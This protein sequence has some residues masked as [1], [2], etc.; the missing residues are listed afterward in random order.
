VDGGAAICLWKLGFFA[1]SLYRE[2]TKKQISHIKIKTTVS[3]HGVSQ[4]I[5]A[6]ILKGK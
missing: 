3:P 5:S 1:I 4:M 6:G 2:E